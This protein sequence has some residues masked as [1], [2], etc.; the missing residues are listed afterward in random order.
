MSDVEHIALLQHSDHWGLGTG[1]V[2][3][4]HWNTG[5]AWRDDPMQAASIKVPASGRQL[6]TDGS[7]LPPSQT[8]PRGM[9]VPTMASGLLAPLWGRRLRI[10][11]AGVRQSNL[12][13]LDRQPTEHNVHLWIRMEH[14]EIFES[15]FVQLC[16]WFTLKNK[17]L[18][19]NLF[20]YY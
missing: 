13:S 10:E 20:I 15:C 1:A 17:M 19:M 4:W 3:V 9:M 11:L 8:P 5:V 12:H 18:N 2:L 14:I 16:C 6:G 7:V